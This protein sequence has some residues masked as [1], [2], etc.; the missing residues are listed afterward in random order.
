M[1]ELEALE[2]ELALREML[3]F[4][5]Q[6]FITTED[7]QESLGNVES[8][9]LPCSCKLRVNAGETKGEDVC[10]F[11]HE[12]GH[13]PGHAASRSKEL[14]SSPCSHKLPAAPKAHQSP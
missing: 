2:L 9:S 6:H 11:H 3:C 10:I 1:Q 7:T 13:I 8:Q 5:S 14:S 4:S 12:D